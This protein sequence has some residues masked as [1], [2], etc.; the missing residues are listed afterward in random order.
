MFSLTGK[1]HAILDWFNVW[2]MRTFNGLQKDFLSNNEEINF[3][4]RSMYGGNCRHFRNFCEQINYK[5]LSS[6]WRKNQI[7]NSYYGFGHEV[8]AVDTTFRTARGFRSF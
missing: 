1:D 2:Q 6:V 7:S 5:T 3:L 8:V 4:I